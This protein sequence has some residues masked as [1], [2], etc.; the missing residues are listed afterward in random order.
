MKHVSHINV[1][2]PSLTRGSR[3][4]TIPLMLCFSQNGKNYCH[5]SLGCTFHA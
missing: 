5:L 1:E 4:L 3:I 2:F